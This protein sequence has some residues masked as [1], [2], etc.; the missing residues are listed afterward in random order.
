[1]GEAMNHPLFVPRVAII[2]SAVL[3]L[4]ALATGQGLSPTAKPAAATKKAGSLP[5]TVDGHP[6][7]Q[8]VWTDNTITPLE[9]P[10]GLGTKEFYTESELAAAQQRERQRLAKNEEEGRP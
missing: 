1:M 9:R 10:K 7:L 2:T 4:C 3:G 6:D 5:R 8:G